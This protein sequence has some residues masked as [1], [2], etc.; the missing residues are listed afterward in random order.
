MKKLR[1]I[2]CTLSFRDRMTRGGQWVGL[3]ARH[4]ARV[5][6]VERGVAITFDD[7]QI[8]PEVE[9]LVLLEKECCRWMDFDLRDDGGALLLTIG[10][11][12]NEGATLIREMVDH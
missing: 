3:I 6:I 7:L 9:Q 8:R 12:S 10:S 1:A 11:D 2:V 5:E 4:R